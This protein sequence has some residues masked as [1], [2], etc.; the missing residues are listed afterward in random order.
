[1]WHSRHFCVHA[2]LRYSLAAAESP[3]SPTNGG[4]RYPPIGG[5]YELASPTPGETDTDTMFPI[6]RGADTEPLGSKAHALPVLKGSRSPKPARKGSAVYELAAPAVSQEPNEPHSSTVRT[7]GSEGVG[8]SRSLAHA[9]AGAGAPRIRMPRG[10]LA[11]SLAWSDQEDS[12]ITNGDPVNHSQQHSVKN[13]SSTAKQGAQRDDDDDDDDDGGDGRG[14]AWLAT[15]SPRPPTTRATT[16]E[17]PYS[18]ADEA[19]PTPAGNTWLATPSQRPPA[20][21]TRA[22]T[23]P[24]AADY[25]SYSYADEATPTRANASPD[26]DDKR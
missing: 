22:S 14:D 24:R 16:V 2:A 23:T 25:P 15:P 3:S 9:A 17:N 5:V 12:S 11:S 19:T 8:S 26:D 21:S 6:S 13:L 4:G 1:M 18:Y 7:G 10:S 20:T